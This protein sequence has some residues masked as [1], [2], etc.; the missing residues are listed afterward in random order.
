ML[1]FCVNSILNP[2][3]LAIPACSKHPRLVMAMQDKSIRLN[4]MPVEIRGRQKP[5][6]LS[7]L[8]CI[9]CFPAASVDPALEPVLKLECSSLDPLLPAPI[10]GSG[11]DS[12]TAQVIFLG[13]SRC[14]PKDLH[15]SPSHKELASSDNFRPGLVVSKNHVRRRGSRD[16]L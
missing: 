7:L 13:A 2:T 15:L 11:L 1:Q 8:R 4:I 9:L 10:F 16:S 12:G 6:N 5:L 14:F 3:E